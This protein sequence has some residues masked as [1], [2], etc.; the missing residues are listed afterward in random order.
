MD[1]KRITQWMLSKTDAQQI[2]IDASFDKMVMHLEEIIQKEIDAFVN[3]VTDTNDDRPLVNALNSCFNEVESD[4]NSDRWVCFEDDIYFDKHAKGF[5]MLSEDKVR[6]FN[7]DSTF[8]S[9]E[10]YNDVI[11]IITAVGGG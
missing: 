4:F 1:T 10:S 3:N 5:W 9:G 6:A 11:E 8:S 7:K 2:G